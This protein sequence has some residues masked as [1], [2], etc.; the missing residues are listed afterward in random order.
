MKSYKETVIF[1]FELEEELDKHNIDYDGDVVAVLIDEDN[2][3]CDRTNC[4]IKVELFISKDE[5]SD[6]EWFKE[7]DPDGYEELNRKLT[8]IRFLCKAFPEDKWIWIEM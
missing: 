3:P 5:E 2:L 4:A 7:N 8:I 6:L 1:Q